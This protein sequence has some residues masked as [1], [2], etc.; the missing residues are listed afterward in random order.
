MNGI[1]VTWPQLLYLGLVLILFY[2]AELLLFLR[3]ARRQPRDGEDHQRV[4]ALEDHVALLHREIEALKIRLAATSHLQ[5]A[6]ELPASET[7]YAHAIRMARQGAD[8]EDMV[9]ECGISRGEADLIAALY[10]A[11]RQG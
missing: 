5:D 10:R 3:K 8:V 9:R 11:E 7:P 4:E 2:V 6:V 1:V